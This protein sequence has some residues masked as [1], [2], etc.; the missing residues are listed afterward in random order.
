MVLLVDPKSGLG[1]AVS[2]LR[3]AILKTSTP[4]TV[5][6]EMSLCG[7]DPNRIAN[8]QRILLAAGAS[9][10]AMGTWRTFVE[11]GNMCTSIAGKLKFQVDSY[12]RVST[13][14]AGKLVLQIE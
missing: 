8:I 10:V 13:I 11:K 4:V 6:L 9:Q 3:A 7:K 14:R 2:Y 1:N 12:D 5:M